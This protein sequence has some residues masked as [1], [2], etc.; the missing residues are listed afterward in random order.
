MENETTKQEKRLIKNFV[1]SL[2]LNDEAKS[3]ASIMTL[4]DNAFVNSKNNDLISMIFQKFLKTTDIH[5]TIPIFAYLSTLSAWCV[6]EKATIKIPK[7]PRDIEL[8]T[9]TM[10]LAK[11]GASKTLASSVI[12]NLVP[13]NSNTDEPFIKDNFVQPVSNASMVEQINKAEN[14][15]LFWKQDEASQFIKQIDNITGPLAQI[16]QTLL[17]LKDHSDIKYATKKEEIV[18]KNPVMTVFMINTIKAMKEAIT[19]ASKYDGT[20]RRFTVAMASSEEN[21]KDFS[22]CALYELDNLKDEVIQ[23][24]FVEVFSKDI[25]NKQFTFTPACRELY[26]EAFEVIWN[27]QYK[28]FMD[29]DHRAYYRTYMMEAWKYAVF[30]HLTFKKEGYIVDIDS[31]QFGI[32]VS[33][34]MLD[35]F[36]EFIKSSID[37]D[38]LLKQI[39]LLDGYIKFIASSENKANF[40]LRQFYRKFHIKREEAID[41]LKRIKIHKPQLKTKLYMEAGIK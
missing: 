12:A 29:E 32:K 26:T 4:V 41:I 10:V 27:R 8:D 31:L 3:L 14:H 5:P 39:Q 20:F 38:D 33:I 34:F 21:G 37:P 7:D 18:I 19:E 11:S 40:N 9:W 17:L 35:S 2:A 24:K 23:E 6:F 1:I 22:E 13:I 25:A 16:K 28:K 15:R 36:Q 30:H